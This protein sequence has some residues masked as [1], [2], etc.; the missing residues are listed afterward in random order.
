[1]SV[2]LRRC[3]AIRPPSSLAAGNYLL[4]T[5]HILYTIG[6]NKVDL[7]GI[8]NRLCILHIGSSASCDHHFAWFNRHAGSQFKIDVTLISPHIPPGHFVAAK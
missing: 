8:D 1:M 5:A 4:A 2:I 6:A 3:R 7:A